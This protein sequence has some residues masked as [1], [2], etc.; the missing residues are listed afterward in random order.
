MGDF[1]QF[2]HFGEVFIQYCSPTTKQIRPAAAIEGIPEGGFL[3]F[4]TTRG[5]GSSWHPKPTLPWSGSLR[6]ISSWC[7]TEFGRQYPEEARSSSGAPTLRKPFI[8]WILE[9][10]KFRSS[11]RPPQDETR[12]E[13]TLVVLRT[14]D[15]EVCLNSRDASRHG[16]CVAGSNK[17]QP[18]TYRIEYS[19][20][21]HLI[22]LRPPK[23]KIRL[24]LASRCVDQRIGRSV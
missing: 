5:N 13:M 18:H 4:L 14:T 16:C 21:R 20:V 10:S 9:L 15:S 2:R 6:S 3:G 17:T 23:G 7:C 12:H 8:L 24:N 11:Y 19:I 22:F 1:E